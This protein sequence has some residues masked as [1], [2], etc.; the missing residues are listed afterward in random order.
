M[1]K[2]SQPPAL[3]LILETDPKSVAAEAYRS[4]RTNLQFSM[5]DQGT[6]KLLI[7]SATPGEGKT[8][9]VA[10]L[11][12]AMAQAGGR[13]CLIDSDLRQPSLHDLFGVSNGIGLTVALAEAKSVDQVVVPTT[14]PNLYLVPSGP[15]PPNPGELLGSNRMR[16]FVESLSRQFDTLLFDSA[17]ILS[18]ADTAALAGLSDGVIL[19]LK[20]GAVPRDL[21]RRAVEQIETVKGK[22]IGVLLSQVDPHRDG[23]YYRYFYQYYGGGYTYGRGANSS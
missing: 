8:T 18:V 9:T 15:V 11:G 2:K 14:L 7:T 13:V 23:Y 12:L 1:L 22:V 5:V 17:P 19:V 20:S 16:E 4:L 10:N 21:L 6:R 3:T